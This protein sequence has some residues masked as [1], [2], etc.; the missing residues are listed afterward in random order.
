MS[1]TITSPKNE[2]LKL[3]RKLAERRTRECK[4]LFVTE[5]EDLLAAGQAAGAEP[6][7]LLSATGSGI[8]GD[9]VDPEA[10]ASASA[11]GSGTR[12]IAIWRIPAG[13]STKWLQGNNNVDAP[14]VYLHGVGDPGNVG[15][16]VRSAA[17]LLGAPVV[18]GPGCADPYG[19]KAVRASMG[20]IF[21]CPPLTEVRLD[22]TPEPRVA[23]IAHGGTELDGALSGPPQAATICLGAERDG[24]PPETLALCERTATI[25]LAAGTESLNVA[26]AAAIACQRISSLVRPDHGDGDA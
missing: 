11:L 22:A 6:Y 18:V 20:A 17:A 19:P 23:L 7:E 24:L 15:A 14:L 3:V 13:A 16:I 4:G 26:A 25:P 10:L 1:E 8:G 5:G 2:K 12:T 9:E 21:T